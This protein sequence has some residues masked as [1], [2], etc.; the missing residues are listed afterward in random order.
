M[1][2]SCFLLFPQIKICGS[3]KIEI[4]TPD[5]A[6]PKDYKSSESPKGE[7]SKKDDRRNKNKI[8]G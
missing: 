5:S 8:T 7:K 2:L 3:P 4:E 1:E 6:L